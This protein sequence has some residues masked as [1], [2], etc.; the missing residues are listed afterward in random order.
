MRRI[1]SIVLVVLYCCL[2]L[3]AQSSPAKL[4]EPGKAAVVGKLADI[5]TAK[6]VFPDTG[7]KMADLIRTNL[8]AGQYTALERPEEFAQ[9]L[10]ADL[11]SVSHD[12]HLRIG[13]APDMIR[14]SKTRTG[15]DDELQR[16]QNRR[17]RMDNYGFQEIKILPGNVGYL[18]FNYF[19]GNPDAF[20]VAVGALA[21]L[22]NADAL[23]I[24]LR[25]NGG[26]DP[27]MIQVITSYFF[28][29]DPKH[30]NSFYHREGDR[31]EQ[32]W[33]LP[34]V[35]GKRL[36]SVPIYVL[37]SNQT[38]SGA[39]EFSYNL[40]NMKRATLVGEITGGGAHPV[41]RE[42]IDDEFWVSVPYARAVN[43]I[44]QTNWEGTGVEPDVKVPA[45]KALDTALVMALEQLS[46]KETEARFQQ[47]YRWHLET[48][49]AKLHPV[50]PSESDLQAYVGS[51]GPRRITLVDGVL[52]YQREDRPKGRLLP[53]TVDTFMLENVPMFRIHFLRE[54]DR[55]TALE[56]RYEDGRTDGN[57]R[58]E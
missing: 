12:L 11:Q 45:D 10:T 22:A 16:L 3:T 53:L 55:V 7:R 47:Y 6:Y 19:S 5:L 24:D 28:E 8:Q 46:G 38:F 23:V 31:T 2:F 30:L 48:Q 40:K 27:Q 15:D 56:G 57:P 29:G 52:Y 17:S 1:I 50:T 58:T 54:G 35:P 42:L 14:M 36:P 18:K 13:Y 21:V 34:Y 37:T 41:K 33:T 44:T 43:P 26:G 32:F 4:D 49:Q 25:E 9:R 39:E 20:P 51:Y